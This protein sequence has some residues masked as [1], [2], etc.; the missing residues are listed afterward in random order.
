MYMLAGPLNSSSLLMVCVW[1]AAAPTMTLKVE[2]G[3]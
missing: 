1:S 3:G 2:P